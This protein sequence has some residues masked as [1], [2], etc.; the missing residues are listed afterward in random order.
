MGIISYAITRIPIKQPG[1]NG[2]C[3]WDRF[4]TLT[5][6]TAGLSTLNGKGIPFFPEIHVLEHYNN[7]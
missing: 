3:T 7:L 1:F 6:Q 2:K 4:Q 5:N